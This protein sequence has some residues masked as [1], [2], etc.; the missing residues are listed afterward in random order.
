MPDSKKSM[1]LAEELAS[2]ADALSDAAF[3]ATHQ[4]TTENLYALTERRQ[5]Y[6]AAKYKLSLHNR[7]EFSQ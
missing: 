6:E 1:E 4:V 2:A 7:K 5:E 3:L